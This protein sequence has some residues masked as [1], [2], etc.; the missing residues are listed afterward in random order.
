[1]SPRTFGRLA[2]SPGKTNLV[3][4]ITDSVTGEQIPAKVQVVN[5]AGHFVHP[6]GAILKVGTGAPFFYSDGKFEVNVSRGWTQVTV[7]RGT[8]YIPAKVAIDAP[9]RGAVAVDV[10]LKR[11]TDL[12]NNGWHPG[13]THIHYDEKEE[14]PDDRLWLDPRVEDLRMTAISILKRWDFDYAS[15]KYP[16]G[17]LSEFSSAHHYVQSGEENRHNGVS[18]ATGYGHIMLLNIRNVVE[19]VSRGALIDAFDPDYPPLSYVCDDAHRQDGIVI[20]CHNGLGMEAP[21]AAALGKVDAF[22]LF[23]PHW[24]DLEYDIYYQMLNAG[25]RL[26]VS[27]GSDWFICSANRV[28]AQTGGQ[29]DYDQWLAALKNGKTFITNGPEL[30]LTVEDHSLGDEIHTSVGTGLGTSV[31]WK[32]HYPVGRAEVLFNGSVVAQQSYPEGSTVGQ[33]NV[34]VVVPSD[35]WIAARLSSDSRDS[36]AQPIFAHTSPVY[37]KCGVD[38]PEKKAAAL[39]FDKA[40]GQSLD[41]VGTKGKFYSDNQRKE[42][43]DLFQQGREVYRSMLK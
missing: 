38:G 41:W 31:N 12:G 24:T 30:S 10:V 20:W 32:S 18:G 28:Y 22:N 5:A 26:P 34:D 9:S 25:I 40:I 23:D 1:M 33:L 35:G 15:N 4:S 29:F 42:I 13:N 37:V 19:P 16:P 14:R 3:G 36:Y 17:M 11:W 7:E 8:E 39:G 2:F 6:D 43:V 21:V 27:T